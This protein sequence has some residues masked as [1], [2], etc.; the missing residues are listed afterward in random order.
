M[1]AMILSNQTGGSQ[2]I[3][4][5]LEWDEGSSGIYF[6]PIVGYLNNNTNL[7]YVFTQLTK[8]NSYQF[9]Y[10]VRNIYGWSAYSDELEQIAARIPDTPLAPQTQNTQT[11][12]TIMWIAPYNGGTIITNFVV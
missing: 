3:S 7:T 10:R 9:K 2:I 12:V 1:T 6:V 5:S 11:S 4:Y 8:G